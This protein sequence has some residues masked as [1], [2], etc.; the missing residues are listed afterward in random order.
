MA[1]NLDEL[2]KAAARFT[3]YREALAKAEI[4]PEAVRLEQA[5]VAERHRKVF[6]PAAERLLGRQRV[7][8]PEVPSVEAVVIV[9]AEPVLPGAGP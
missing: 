5:I 2:Q 9:R 6:R 7:T 8:A 1:I 3:D 4:M